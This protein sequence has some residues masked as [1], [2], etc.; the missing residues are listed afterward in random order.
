MVIESVGGAE[1]EGTALYWWMGFQFKRILTDWKHG[2]KKTKMQF[3]R[4]KW[5]SADRQAQSA[6]QIQDLE[7]LAEQQTSR[8][9]FKGIS[10]SQVEWKS[11][12]LYCW[13]KDKLYPGKIKRSRVNKH[14]VYLSALLSICNCSGVAYEAFHQ[15]CGRLCRREKRTV[16]DQKSSSCGR[17]A[18]RSAL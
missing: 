16:R 18:E 14:M 4:P 3:K 12:M 9:G 6:T 15:R 13:E 10:R 17:Q 7:K 8:Q 1:M 2:L 11:I 5:N